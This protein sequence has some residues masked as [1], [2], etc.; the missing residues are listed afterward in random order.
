MNNTNLL[1]R[2]RSR[3]KENGISLIELERKLNLAKNSIYKW[4]TSTPPAEKINEMANILNTSTD[5][6]LGR[7]D[8][9]TPIDVYFRIDMKNV[10]EDKRE[11]FK[12]ELT[13]LRDFAFKRLQEE[14]KKLDDQEKNN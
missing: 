6:L 5:Y 10:P 14:E 3:A 4:K 1:D 7:T 13:L 12:K 8:D 9:P 2:I 11:D